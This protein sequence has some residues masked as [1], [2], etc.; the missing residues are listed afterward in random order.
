[1]A[2]VIIVPPQQRSQHALQN[3]D[4]TTVLNSEPIPREDPEPAVGSFPSVPYQQVPE[5]VHSVNFSDP[6]QYPKL[7]E[8]LWHTLAV[9]ET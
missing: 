8:V 9:Q 5:S 4:I 6:M 2:E 7:N 1:M 3:G